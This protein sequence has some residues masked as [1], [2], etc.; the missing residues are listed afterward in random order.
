MKKLKSQGDCE[1]QGGKLLRLLSGF[2]PIIRPLVLHLLNFVLLS[3][4]SKIIAKIF[5]RYTFKKKRRGGSVIFVTI[6]NIS[7]VKYRR[8]KLAC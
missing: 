1:Q 2:R 3:S 8:Y 7:A 5:A 6:K 4:F